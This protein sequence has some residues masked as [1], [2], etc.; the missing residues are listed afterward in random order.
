MNLQDIPEGR[1]LFCGHVLNTAICD[2][3]SEHPHP[4]DITMCEFCATWMIFDED[5]R[6]IA[7]NKFMRAIIARHPGCQKNLYR[8][9]RQTMRN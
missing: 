5:L 3:T 6:L 8:I 1:C 4:G 7:P 9:H 2:E